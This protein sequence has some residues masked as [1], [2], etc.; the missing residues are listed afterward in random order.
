MKRSAVM[1]ATALLVGLGML[2]TASTA[3]AAGLKCTAADGKTAC[4]A[5]QVRDI[6]TGIMTGKRQHKPFLMD[7]ESV[8]L[9]V[10]GALDCKQINGSVCTADQLS[11]V[12]AASK[13]SGGGIQVMKVVDKASPQ[14]K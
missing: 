10:N 7:V 8:S 12:I 6:N 5:A 3:R 4:S 13:Q 11:A 1:A 2:V 9:G 14:L